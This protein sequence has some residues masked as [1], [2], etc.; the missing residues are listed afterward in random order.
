MPGFTVAPNVGSGLSATNLKPFY[1]YTWEIASL[2]VDPSDPAGTQSPGASPTGLGVIIYAKDCTLP[3]F[4]TDYE[5]V[6]GASV[7]YKYASMVNW[8]DIRITFY[9]IPKDGEIMAERLK[10]WRDR[11]WTP[12]TGLG[13]ADH[14]KQQSI[15]QVFNLDITE[16]YKWILYGSW[17]QSIRDGELT[18]TRTEVKLVEVVIVYDW[19]DTERLSSG[20]LLM[21]AG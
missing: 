19:A 10:L 21:L 2:F 8:E 1:S 9:D 6:D 18:Y 12:G 13:F 16:G 17:P 3:T 5:R 20:E 14:Y 7:V 4:S 15:I 11:V